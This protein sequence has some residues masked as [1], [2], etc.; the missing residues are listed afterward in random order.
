MVIR[1]VRSADPIVDVKDGTEWMKGEAELQ[2]W[3]DAHVLQA[4]H[5]AE[6][7]R[8]EELKREVRLDLVKIRRGQSITLVI[9]KTAYLSSH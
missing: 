2:G 8:V 6:T 9:M 4:L 5:N 3:I 1:T 7:G